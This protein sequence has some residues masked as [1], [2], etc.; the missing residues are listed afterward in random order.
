MRKTVAPPAAP[1]LSPARIWQRLRPRLLRETYAL[2]VD[3][4]RVLSGVL[5]LVYF[6][7]LF[8]QVR[9]FSS[10]DGLIDHALLQKIFWYTRIGLFQAEL[11]PPDGVFYFLYAFGALGCLA[12]VAGWRVKLCAALLFIIA[13]S[14][15]RWN[16]IV[17]Y[18][19]DSI[20]HL[21]LFWLLLLP[22]GR[23]LVLSEW[24][25]DGSAAW[26]RWKTTV[27]PGTTVY[28]LLLNL[29]LLYVVAGLWKLESPLWLNGFALYA[30]L[31]LPIAYWPDYWGPQHLPVLAVF[32]HAALI[33]EP[34]TPVLLWLR[35]NHP[36]KWIGLLLMVGF[37]LG[38]IA[39][40]RIPYA[41]IACIAAAVLWFRDEIMQWLLTPKE[42]R[43]RL[44]MRPAFDRAGRIAL[45]FIALMCVAQTR[46]LTI[47]WLSYQPAFAVLW[48]GGIAQDYQLFN[49]IHTK[50]WRGEH[51][52]FVTAPGANPTPIDPGEFFPSS[53]RAVLLQSYLH[54]VRW[55]KIPEEN[56]PELKRAIL[57]RF[58][59]HFCRDHPRDGAISV[60][61]RVH[62][63]LPED[64]LLLRGQTRFLVEF[65]CRGDRAIVCQTMLDSQR[66]GRCRVWGPSASAGR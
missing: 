5:L 36:L 35:R 55:I 9:D 25:R 4:F 37:H 60:T 52:V 28:C 53:L 30:A 38:I 32:T 58:A 47:L 18:V 41:N 44:G 11:A 42:A 39:T 15:Q 27:V 45:I 43:A 13:V 34:L 23:T 49:W 19:D 3:F 61:S 29:S 20:M 8:V 24:R 64:P 12:I 33:V 7:S 16:F 17:M 21:V 22:V 62:Q 57:A 50:N 59:N 1:A 40:L 48:F 6:V 46:R 66:S 51:S 63:I 31:R 10:R 2:P 56:R 26:E 14:A 54:D 65:E